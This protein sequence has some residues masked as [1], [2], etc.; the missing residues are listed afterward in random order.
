MTF[1]DQIQH[2]DVEI[3]EQMREVMYKISYATNTH[4]DHRESGILSPYDSRFRTNIP[5]EMF[6]SMTL[7][8][9]HVP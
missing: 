8:S 9:I 7:L 1:N 4:G 2:I 5:M 6:S 3:Q